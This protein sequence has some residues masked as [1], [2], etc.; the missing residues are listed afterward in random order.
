MAQKQN[1]AILGGGIAAITTAMELTSTPELR[2]RYDVTVYQYGWRLGGK[3]ASGRNPHYHD[4]IEEHGLHI[5][6][7]FYENAFRLMRDTYD[8]LGRDPSQPLAGWRDA[9]KPCDDIVLYE[10]HDGRWKGWNFDIPRNELTPGD[11]NPLP[12]FW[13]VAHTMLDYFLSQWGSLKT[14]HPEA[15]PGAGRT[16]PSL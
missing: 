14:T 8:E 12:E 7:G 6:F 4:R 5:W 3:C 15:Q 2:R 9:F 11:S 10:E 16:L 13:E 1:I